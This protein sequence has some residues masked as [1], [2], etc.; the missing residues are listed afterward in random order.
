MERNKEQ[1]FDQVLN[2]IQKHYEITG[3]DPTVWDLA[4]AVKV[5]PNRM[6]AIL[7]MMKEQGDLV[8]ILF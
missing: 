5:K 2:S 8:E 4:L 3:E 1:L 6:V 7:R